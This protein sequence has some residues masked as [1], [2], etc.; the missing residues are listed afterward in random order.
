MESKLY[1]TPEE[2][3]RDLAKTLEA[4][5]KF[6]LHRSPFDDGAFRKREGA[7]IKLAKQ[8][9]LEVDALIDRKG[10]RYIVGTPEQ[11]ADIKAKAV[12]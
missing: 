12:R 6:E 9:G 11:I 1:L 5:L 8:F 4:Q 3:Q 2:A 10:L 7:I